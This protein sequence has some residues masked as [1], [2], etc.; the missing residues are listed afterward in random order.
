MCDEDFSFACPAHW[1]LKKEKQQK[2]CIPNS[3][4]QVTLFI[5]FATITEFLH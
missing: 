4:Y 1:K 5:N 3:R 2:F